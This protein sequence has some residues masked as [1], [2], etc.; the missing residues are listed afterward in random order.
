MA[1]NFQ[2]LWEDVKNTKDEAKAVRTLAEVVTEKDGRAFVSRFDREN[3]EYCV[4]VLGRVSRYSHPQRSFVF[5]D[6]F[7]R[8]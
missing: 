3:A 8:E 5:S 7:V 2:R 6:I 4:D 1:N